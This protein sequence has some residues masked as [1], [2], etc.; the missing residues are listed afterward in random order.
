[1]IRP[2]L[3]EEETATLV[4]L[5]EATGLFKLHEIEAAL[6]EASTDYFAEEQETGHRCVTAEENGTLLGFAD[7]WP[8]LP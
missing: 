5:T 6:D 3:P 1:M 8:W 2:T 4:E 7:H